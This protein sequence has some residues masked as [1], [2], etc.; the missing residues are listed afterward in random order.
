[1]VPRSGESEKKLKE[2]RSGMELARAVYVH[3]QPLFRAG[4]VLDSDDIDVLRKW[5]IER[6]VIDTRQ[7]EA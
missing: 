3:S 1:M 4:T 5:N 2:L 7:E 6:V